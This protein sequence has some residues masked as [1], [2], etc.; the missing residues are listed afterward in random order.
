MLALLQVDPA[1]L[2][3][4]WLRARSGPVR[5]SVLAALNSLAPGR[6]HPGIDDLALYGGTDLAATLA[7]GHT[8]WQPGLLA[9]HS[10]LVLTMAERCPASLAARLAQTLDSGCLAV[11][12]LDEASENGEGLPQALADRLGLFLDLDGLV[13][14][15]AALNVPD[16]TRIAAARQR[17]PFVTVPAAILRALAEGAAALGICSQR[18]EWLASRTARALAALRDDIVVTEADAEL[19]AAL[20]MGHRALPAPDNAPQDM[21]EDQPPESPPPEGDSPSSQTPDEVLADLLVET[22]KAALPPGLLDQLAA[23]RA[24]RAS[25]SGSGAGAARKGNRRGRPL[26]SRAGRLGGQARV[27]VV[28]SL[29]AAAPWQPIRRRSFPALS[30][31]KLILLPQDIRL[32]RFEDCSDRL[33]IFAVDAS[34][35]AAMARLGEAK[36]AVECL[37]AEAY[38]RRDHVA[39]IV[40]RGTGAELVLPPTRSLVQ[41]RKRLAGTPGGGGTPLA[42]ALDLGQEV[43]RQARSRGMTPTLA[44]LTDGR[45]N[46]ARDGRGDRMQAASDAAQAARAVAACGIPA[47]V[48]DTAIRPQPALAQLAAQMGGRLLPLPRSDSRGIA[49]AVATAMDRHP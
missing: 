20:A 47:L 40:F 14:S 2:G 41:A 10:A 33:L 44:L 42:A 32:K 26:P 12:A 48:I 37:L 46:I 9:R 11:I 29:R 27:D 15:E 36:G 31:R 6:L 24:A 5:A 49:G 30:D 19:A 4:V 3:G 25:P 16:A 23:A 13:P 45:A 21:P 43:A 8:V 39:L 34:G 28:A 7:E 35:S 38:S 22:V 18:A 1:G 17:L